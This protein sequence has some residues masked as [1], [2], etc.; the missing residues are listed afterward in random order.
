[1]DQIQFDAGLLKSFSE[2]RLLKEYLSQ[3]CSPAL[4]LPRIVYDNLD[5][6]EKDTCERFLFQGA[7]CS[8]E[9]MS[10]IEDFRLAELFERKGNYNR[11]H[12]LL[13]NA[14]KKLKKFHHING[15]IKVIFKLSN[16][17]PIHQFPSFFVTAVYKLF[18]RTSI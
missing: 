4:F 18:I 13:A 17:Q 12:E 5:S 1:L 16:T 3:N 9:E 8:L 7:P 14:K 11:A 6:P 2:I 15:Q 10:A